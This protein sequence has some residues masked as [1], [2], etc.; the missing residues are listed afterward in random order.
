[1][2]LRMRRVGALTLIFEEPRVYFTNFFVGDATRSTAAVVAR[3]SSASS[4]LKAPTVGRVIAR[5]QVRPW[6]TSLVAATGRIKG[7]D[8]TF[9][10][11]E[12]GIYRV[13]DHNSNAGERICWVLV[14]DGFPRS[15]SSDEADHRLNILFP[16]PPA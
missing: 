9:P 1:M 5:D 11:V 13:V 15:L 10:L 3:Q 6:V 8:W 2:D 12:D 7:G 16:P 14:E 4:H